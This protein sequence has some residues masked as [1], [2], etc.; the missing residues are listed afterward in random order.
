MNND[1]P[2]RPSS[3]HDTVVVLAGGD[4]PPAW[5]SGELPEKVFVIAA[6]SGLHHA[7]RLGLRVDVVIGD[8]DSVEAEVL[9]RHA[10]ARIV[11]HSPQKDR[12]DLELALEAALSLDPTRVIVVGGSGGRLD[13]L[14]ANAALLAAEKF[15]QV[16]MMWMAAGSAVHVV[17]AA[18]EIHGSQGDTV[19][20][21]ALG[22]Q[23]SG[24]T[25]RGLQW[26]LVD[27][28]LEFGTTWGVSN[29]MTG[30]VARVQV[31][32][33]MLLVVHTPIDLPG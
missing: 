26:A 31:R 24:V 18:L 27:A 28:T 25:T 21:L 20:L 19:S 5:V 11:S 29:R 6:D 14:L 33:G 12:T 10:E 3:D 1:L 30:P 9:T 13:H 4:P 32:Q 8:L 22:G 16:D 15:A 2:P 23:V 7:S 17:R